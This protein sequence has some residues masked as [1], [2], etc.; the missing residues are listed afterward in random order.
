LQREALK[1]LEASKMHESSF[2]QGLGVSRHQNQNR[3]KMSSL[4]QDLDHSWVVQI[5]MGTKN[6]IIGM[7]TNGS[8]GRNGDGGQIEGWLTTK[9]VISR[10]QKQ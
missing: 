4:S 5:S 7:R 9:V 2:A 3:W 8:A 10:L 6:L 1:I